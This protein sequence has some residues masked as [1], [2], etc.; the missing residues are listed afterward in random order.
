MGVLTYQETGNTELN[1]FQEAESK[2]LKELIPE[3]VSCIAV[4]FTSHI[5][6]NF[7]K[8]SEDHYSFKQNTLN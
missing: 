2:C 7:W 5:L 1:I 3:L 4:C 6:F 8:F